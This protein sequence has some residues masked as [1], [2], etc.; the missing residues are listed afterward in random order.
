M[1]KKRHSQYNTWQ[2]NGNS[3]QLHH[4]HYFISMITLMFLVLKSSSKTLQK[5]GKLSYQ[6]TTFWNAFLQDRR[7]FGGTLLL[8]WVSK[9]SILSAVTRGWLHSWSWLFS[10]PHKGKQ[11][12]AGGD[13]FLR[14]LLFWLEYKPWNQMDYIWILAPYLKYLGILRHVFFSYY[15]LKWGFISYYKAYYNFHQPFNISKTRM[16]L[17]I[18]SVLDPI[19]YIFAV[20]SWRNYLNSLCLS[21]L[22]K[23]GRLIILTS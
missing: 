5:K 21:F 17:I 23:M 6:K 2:M 15:K 4:Y 9:N 18:N 3:L 19:K 14:H 16:F 1:K 12:G 7:W 10:G 22:Y 13:F 20:W 11:S 8:S